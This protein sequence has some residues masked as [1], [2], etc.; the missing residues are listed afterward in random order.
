MSELPT[1]VIFYDGVC[2][3]CNGI[4]K[5]LLRLDREKRFFFAPLQGETATRAR[6]RHLGLP[7]EME[8]VVYLRDDEVFLRSEA[9]LQALGELP[10][11][12]KALSWLRIVPRCVTDFVYRGVARWRYRVFGKYDTCPLPPI[13]DR[14]R[15]LP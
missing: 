1:H 5:A 11:P 4:V 15:F 13:E 12:A 3:M 7:S 9:A 8:T 2:V 10:Y 6:E 14:A